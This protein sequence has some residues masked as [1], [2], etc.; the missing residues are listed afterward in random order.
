MLIIHPED[1]IA[2]SFN[3][4][5]ETIKLYN[6]I[7]EVI[8]EINIKWFCLI[9]QAPIHLAEKKSSKQKELLIIN[10]LIFKTTDQA[11]KC[12]QMKIK[13]SVAS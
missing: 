12:N 11:C 3:A 5:L 1:K 6:F 10:S 9:K 7:D 13:M 8:S 2:N 4:K